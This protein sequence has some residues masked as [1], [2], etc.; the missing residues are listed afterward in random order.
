MITGRF[1]F[2]THDNC[3]TCCNRDKRAVISACK[4]L[5]RIFTR[6]AA[7]GHTIAPN[8]FPRHTA[9][10]NTA[11]RHSFTLTHIFSCFV[12]GDQ[13]FLNV[14][15]RSGRFQENLYK[16]CFNIFV[17]I[18]DSLQVIAHFLRKRNAFVAWT[19]LGCSNYHVKK[20]SWTSVLA[21]SLKAKMQKSLKVYYSCWFSNTK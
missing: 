9:S 5:P 6:V 11:V 15:H 4:S 3:Q 20:D 16:I 17:H 14:V 13:K 2:S 21:L 1:N 18:L 7:K 12:P 10:R 19:A 8:S